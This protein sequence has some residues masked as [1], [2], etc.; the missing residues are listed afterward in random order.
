LKHNGLKEI[1]F[2]KWC[3]RKMEKIS[4]TDRVRNEEMLRRIKEEGNILYNEKKVR[5][6]V[7]VTSCVRI[8]F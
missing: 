4:R 1:G 5:L 7:F 2:E 3:W 8:T 6:I